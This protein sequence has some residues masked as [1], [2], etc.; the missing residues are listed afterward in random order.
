MIHWLIEDVSML[1][2]WL[3]GWAVNGRAESVVV[4]RSRRGV[5]LGSPQRNDKDLLYQL[6][7]FDR[8]VNPHPEYAMHAAFVV[9]QPNHAVGATMD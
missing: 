7:K 1:T 9:Y 2:K 6:D 4:R 8:V 3:I 5:F